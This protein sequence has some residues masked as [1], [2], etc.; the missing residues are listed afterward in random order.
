VQHIKVNA[1]LFVKYT[2]L[3]TVIYGCMLALQDNE[4]NFGRVLHLMIAACWND[5]MKMDLFANRNVAEEL[6][7]HNVLRTLLIH[8]IKYTDV[9]TA[10]LFGVYLK[11]QSKSKYFHFPNNKRL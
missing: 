9:D 6:V 1:F 3:Y 10:R 11:E 4:D 7:E 8:A 5:K 2:Y